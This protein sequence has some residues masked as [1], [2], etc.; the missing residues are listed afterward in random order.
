M[1]KGWYIERRNETRLLTNLGEL[2]YH[3]TY[4]HNKETDE[5]GYLL[6]QLMSWK[7]MQGFRKMRNQGNCNEEN[8]WVEVSGDEASG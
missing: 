7:N 6:N 4:F 8:S 5:Y 3:K 2:Q 1:R